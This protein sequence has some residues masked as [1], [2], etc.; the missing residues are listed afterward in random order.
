MIKG[1]ISL[2]TSGSIFKPTVLSG[3]LLGF[4][5]ITKL[6]IEKIKLII[7]TPQNYFV[8]LSFL[9]C[10]V[11]L[12]KKTFKTGGLKIDFFATTLTVIAEFIIFLL[13]YILSMSFVFI[14]GF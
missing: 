14:L 10:Y 6:S 8:L 12:F 1:I 5:S 2:F 4:F 7:T 13:S 9:L 11:F 3:I